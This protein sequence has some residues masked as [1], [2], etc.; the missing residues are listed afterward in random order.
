MLSKQSNLAALQQRAIKDR[1]LGLI[2]QS[3][4]LNIIHKLDRI[5]HI[6]ESGDI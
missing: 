6:K 1:E 5:S 3:Q 4:L 2:T